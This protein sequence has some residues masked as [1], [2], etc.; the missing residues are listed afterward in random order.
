MLFAF[1][2]VFTFS[3]LFCGSLPVVYSRQYTIKFITQRAKHYF[4]HSKIYFLVFLEAKNI[5]GGSTKNNSSLFD[6]VMQYFR[7]IVATK[8][9]V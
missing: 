1:R 3:H 7:N 5:V 6:L 9:Q 4:A 2:I 8:L